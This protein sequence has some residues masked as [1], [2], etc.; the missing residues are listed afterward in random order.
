MSS[1]HNSLPDNVNFNGIIL[2]DST[3]FTLSKC[4]NQGYEYIK[5]TYKIVGVPLAAKE[6]EI[7]TSINHRNINKIMGTGNDNSYYYVYHDTFD[8]IIKA[9]IQSNIMFTIK[10]IYRYL[11][12]FC[13]GL[14]CLRD[15]EIIH[16]DIAP[17]NIYIGFNGELIISNFE[18]SFRYNHAE[19]NEEIC[20]TAGYMYPELYY[21]PQLSTYNSDVFSLG[22][23]MYELYTLKRAF[24]N[25][26]IQ[27]PSYNPPPPHRDINGDDQLEY[28]IN[29][30]INRDI[31]R[32]S[33]RKIREIIYNGKVLLIFFRSLIFLDVKFSI[34]VKTYKR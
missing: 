22:C 13:D 16:R 19:E 15:N 21:D 5:K 14:M 23:I 11:N 29:E 28:L 3:L 17:R 4:E 8:N 20:P 30:M 18:N 34:V 26:N 2:R 27:D 1:Y 31:N 32:I 6:Y 24:N 7:L 10:E 9:H 25:R 33:I 12:D